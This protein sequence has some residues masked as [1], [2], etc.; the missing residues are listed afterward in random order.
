LTKNDFVPNKSYKIIKF[1]NEL[2]EKERK[3]LCEQKTTFK[4][5]VIP[6]GTKEIEDFRFNGC[7]SLESITIPDSVTKIGES[8]FMGCSSLKS[9]KIPS[10]IKTIKK[11][12]FENCS[13]LNSVNLPDGLEIIN[14]KAFANCKSLQE[15]IIPSHI[16]YVSDDAFEGCKITVLKKQNLFGSTYVLRSGLVKLLKILLWF[17]AIICFIV[18][19]EIVVN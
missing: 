14:R 15:I 9:I 16:E 6:E 1:P 11:S 13:S 17:I 7:T 3:E 18:I 8:A 2:N 10:K 4:S 5:I 19:Y 12:T